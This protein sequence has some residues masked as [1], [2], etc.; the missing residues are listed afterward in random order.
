MWTYIY[1]DCD[2]QKIHPRHVWLAFCGLAGSSYHLKWVWGEQLNIFWPCCRHRMQCNVS[3]P[4]Y[5]HWIPKGERLG[6]LTFISNGWPHLSW[7]TWE[8]T[9]RR[10]LIR[11]KTIV[12]MT[13]LESLVPSHRHI[14]T[15]TWLGPSGLVSFSVH[16]Y[17][18]HSTH[19]N[20][21]VICV[22]LGSLTVARRS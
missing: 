13:T 21:P 22:I 10:T 4:E 1:L 11:I 9:L 16:I 7:F 6:W 12:F 8:N 14:W 2:K 3:P 17:S 5:C 19:T 15:D 18:N 20:A